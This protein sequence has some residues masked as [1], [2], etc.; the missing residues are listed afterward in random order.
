M[1]SNKLF[2]APEN[3]FGTIKLPLADFKPYYRGQEMLQDEN[4]LDTT[5]ITSIGLKVDMSPYLPENQAGVA[6]LEIDW[7]KAIK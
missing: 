2:Q 6:A 7:I 1:I 4:P 3:E 5:S